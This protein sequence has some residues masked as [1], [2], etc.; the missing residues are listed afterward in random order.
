MTNCEKYE[1]FL[2]ENTDIML[3]YMIWEEQFLEPQ[4]FTNDVM[5]DAEEVEFTEITNKNNDNEN[6]QSN[7]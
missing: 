4:I 3:K 6:L 2:E 7:S 1:K 5:I